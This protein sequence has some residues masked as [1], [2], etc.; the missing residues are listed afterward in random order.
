LDHRAEK[1]LFDDSGH[2][3]FS[4][5][6]EDATMPLFL[7]LI[8][9]LTVSL[10][11]VWWVKRARARR[12]LERFTMAPETLYELLYPKRKVL[13]FDVRLPLDLLAHPELIPGAV[14]IAPKEVLANPKLL[15]KDEDAVIYCTCPGDKTSQSVMQ[16]VLALHFTKVKMLRG[17][18]EAWKAQ[19]YPVERFDTPFRLDTAS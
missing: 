13:V 6:P 9:V 17:G 1:S 10:L 11:A 16:K 7:G 14:R 12:E 2:L 19:G 18:L 5:F 3:I 15:P 8:V 4:L